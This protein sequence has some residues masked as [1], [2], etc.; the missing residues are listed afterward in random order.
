MKFAGYEYKDGIYFVEKLV[1]M[2][3]LLL[4]LNIRVVRPLRWHTRAH[5]SHRPKY[6]KTRLLPVVRLQRASPLF[7]ETSWPHTRFA[8][9]YRFVSEEM[10]IKVYEETRDR[11][12]RALLG[13]IAPLKNSPD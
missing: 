12:P 13:I 11:R 5:L 8:P 6:N 10:A 7:L 2:S 4:A 3:A 1:G 9:S